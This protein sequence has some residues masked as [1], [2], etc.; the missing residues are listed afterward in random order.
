MLTSK[1]QVLQISEF[2]ANLLNVPK[3]GSIKTVQQQTVFCFLHEECVD[4]G[5]EEHCWGGSVWFGCTCTSGSARETG[6]S[7]VEPSDGHT[8]YEYTCCNNGENQ[9]E[10]CGDYRLTRG[11]ALFVV[12]PS[13]LAQPPPPPSTHASRIPRTQTFSRPPLSPAPRSPAPTLLT[14]RCPSACTARRSPPSP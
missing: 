6:V 4:L 1:N 2:S 3:N 13:R 8:Y 12:R 5:G 7:S 11:S 9:G 14:D 10:E